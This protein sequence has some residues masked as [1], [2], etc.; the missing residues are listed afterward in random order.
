[1]SR[2]QRA[3]R[4]CRALAQPAVP[5]Y[6]CEPL[7]P[8]TLLSAIPVDGVVGNPI[9]I[10]GTSGNDTIVLSA[11]TSRLGLQ[12]F[13]DW[14]I[15]GGPTQTLLPQPGSGLID[16]I[17]VASCQADGASGI[18]TDQ[19]GVARPQGAGCDSGAVEVAVPVATPIVVTPS[20]T[21]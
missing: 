4:L 19:R 8:R 3:G 20:F 21:G 16:A 10:N 5:F 2:K 7:E 17:P 12:F 15:N 1:M 6:C 9:V 13:V 18:T 11:H 14:S